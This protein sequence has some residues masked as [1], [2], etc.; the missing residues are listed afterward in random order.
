MC[1]IVGAL[2]VDGFMPEALRRALTAIRHRGPDSQG[3]FSTHRV[4]LGMRRLAVIDVAGGQQPVFNEDR[5]IAVVFNGEIYNYREL[6][7]DLR[8]RGH[9]FRSESDTETLVHL[10]EEWGSDMCS[11]LRGMFAF[12]IWDETQGRLLLARDRFGKKPLYLSHLGNGGIVF[13]S[14]LKA[15]RPLLQAAAIPERINP[16][17]IYDYLSLGC[18]PQPET[19][20]DGVEALAPGQWLSVTR[21][22]CEAG[23]YWQLEGTED[24]Q[25]PSYESAQARTRE[26]V[27]EAVRIRLRSD[28]PLGL[29]LSGGLDSSVVAYE[30][31]RILGSDLQTYTIA[32]ADGG[33]DESQMAA[34]TARALGV[35]NQVLPLNVVPIQELFSLVQHFDQPYADSSAIASVSVARLARQHVTVVL[36]GDGGD[37]VFGGYRRYVAA[38]WHQALRFI[39]PVLAAAAAALCSSVSAERRSPLGFAARFL[40]GLPMPIEQRYL[41]WTNDLL[42]EDLKRQHWRGPAVRPT[43][44]WL[45][46]LV[47]RRTTSLKQQMLMDMRVNLLSDLLVKMDMAT[48]A[49]SVEGRSP[50]L[51]HTLAEFTQTLPDRYLVR[52]NRTKCLLRDAYADRLPVEVLQGPKRGFE[53][54]LGRWLSGPLRPLV[55]DL[56]GR[57]NAFVRDWV[58]GA[59]IDRLLSVPF[60]KTCN[61]DAL[62]YALL[63][64]EIWIEQQSGSGTAL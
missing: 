6:L 8:K 54:P 33:L 63:V 36:N 46:T 3:E 4:A 1:G 7:A 2:H 12:A 59:Y 55:H 35:R 64:L 52:G 26:L 60:L 21:A 56:L 53:V 50:L 38:S 32:M 47:P 34:R 58:D 22:G 39:P 10:Y 43:E 15:L 11:R 29:F 17:A 28:V 14:E 9:V 16:R 62:V 23:A 45:A 25:P 19:I 31:A 49:A 48:M 13:A 18:I 24:A 27:A 57:P 61:R 20:Y 51:D 44:Q 40:R 37:E 5:T 30:A 42:K 41:H